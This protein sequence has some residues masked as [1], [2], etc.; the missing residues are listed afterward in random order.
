MTKK[1]K[2]II[3][4]LFF[5]TKL[6]SQNYSTLDEAKAYFIKNINNLS[7]IEGIWSVSSTIPKEVFGFDEDV[8]SIDSYQ[9]AIIK[10]GDIFVVYNIDGQKLT[11]SNYNIFSKTSS[12]ALYI[13][14]IISTGNNSNHKFFANFSEKNIFKVEKIYKGAIFE[15]TTYIRIFPDDNTI[16]EV[17]IKSQKSTGTGF[18]ISSNGYITTCNHVIDGATNI[19]VKGVGGNFSKSY[20]A[21]VISSDVN[22]D[23]SIIKIDDTSFTTLGAI[24]FTISSTTSD[25]GSNIFIMGYPLTATMGDEIKLTNGIISAKSG[26]KGDITSYQISAAAQSGNSG[27]PLFDAKGNLIGVVNAKHIK[28]ESATYAVKSTYLKNLIDAISTTIKLT[29]INSLTGKSLTEQVKSIKNYVY[30]IEV[31]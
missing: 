29:T 10:Q 8:V 22:N 1:T 11:L 3:I 30:I 28:A 19:K 21:K 12:S 4:F 14:E 7:S 26:F 18:A 15:K 5:A 2:T 9:C 31:N 16:A 13:F 23:L 25:V 24:P 17:K 20:T 27:G 6:F